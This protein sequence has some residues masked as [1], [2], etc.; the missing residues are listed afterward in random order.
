MSVTVQNLT[1]AIAQ[2]QTDLATLLTDLTAQVAALNA[3]ITALQ[4]TATPDLSGV[5]TAVQ[6]L[7]A[8]IKAATP[9][10]AAPTA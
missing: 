4:G 5:L 9:A 2:S 1:D 8:S 10:P 7:D 6:A 3:Q